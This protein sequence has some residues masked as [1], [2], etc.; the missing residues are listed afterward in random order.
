MNKKIVNC[1]CPY[2]IE[3]S[4]IDTIDTIDNIYS[5][6]SNYIVNDIENFKNIVEIIHLR[7]LSN[8]IVNQENRIN[9]L[10]KLYQNTEEKYNEILHFLGLK[11]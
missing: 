5:N 9:G 2:C 4:N 10:T 6:S 7:N 8:I 11:T 3:E 1:L